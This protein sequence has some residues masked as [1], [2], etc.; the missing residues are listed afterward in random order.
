MIRKVRS[1]YLFLLA[2]FLSTC[3]NA[4]SITDSLE[5]K[6]YKELQETFYNQLESNIIKAKKTA[7][8]Y[9][10]RA[11][12]NQD[13]LRIAYAYEFHTNLTSS[14]NGIRYYDSI[15]AITKNNP[16][17]RYP[18]HSYFRK[19]QHYLYEKRDIKKTLYNLSEARKQATD[20]DNID[21]LY[22]TDYLIGI[23]KSEHL[24][25]KENAISIFKK[26]ATY[27][28][29]EI[30]Y[31]HKFRYL[32]TLHV[33]AETY[34]GLKKYDSATYY[35]TK[36]YL[37]SSKSE[38]AYE[39]QMKSYFTL[40]EGINKYQLKEY[41]TA[42]DSINIALPEIIALEDKSNTI[43]SYFYLGQSY[44]HLAEEDKAISYLKK[45]D[46]ILET[47]N[48]IPQYKH[49]KTYEYLK[50]YY[51]KKKDIQNQNKYLDKLNSI[52]D[53]YINDKI[54]ISTKVKE[55]YDVPVLLDEQRAVINKL[56]NTNNKYITSISLLIILLLILGSLLYYFYH[57]KQKYR[58]R[59]EQLM[60]EQKSKMEATNTKKETNHIDQNK[61]PL[62]IP[63]KHIKH[64]LHRLEEFENEK[65]FL[66]NG[67]SA[68]S[69]ADIM[70][71]N[72]KYLSKVINFYK[73]KTFT[74]YLN[75]LRITF[76]LSELKEN[77]TLRKYTIKAI[78]E[79]MGY[80]S[81]ETFSNAFYKQ[82]GIK[83]SYFIN[84]IRKA[85]TVNQ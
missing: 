49:V 82:V 66:V 27:Y 73:D 70:E 81:S 62:D 20:N 72:V 67:I 30:K 21:L 5:Q 23:V 42:I 38:D 45:T 3:I 74:N 33:T 47:L 76:A 17:K 85:E 69:M 84:Q 60:T 12:N 35:N 41:P 77:P 18:A 40:C 54:Y 7:E 56:N 50:N 71:T 4:Q 14:E 37:K 24:G 31:A 19:A 11:K 78:A 51:K 36:G 59:F 10:N 79:E 1:S 58:L 16:T 28:A 2:S 48:S 39:I 75:E 46:S 57:K 9:L 55:D 34:I 29:K 63:E 44:Y 32:S 83:P 26:C 25:E 43:D 80:N 68:Q 52:L 61:K 65:G 13:T 8:V 22:R 6:T 15:I 53:S 64:I